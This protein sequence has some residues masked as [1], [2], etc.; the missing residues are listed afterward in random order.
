MT[1]DFTLDAQGRALLAAEIRATPLPPLDPEI[2]T[3]I[4]RIHRTEITV[5]T[6]HGP[7][8]VYRLDPRGS[9]TAAR[10][11]YINFHGG[12]FVRPHRDHDTAFC[13][14][15]ALALDCVVFDVDYRLAPEH[16]F[17]IPAEEGH[18]VTTWIIRQAK[19]LGLD[20]A[21]IVIGGHSAGANL[22]TVICQMAARAGTPM[23]TGQYL[24]YPF[25]DAITPI[26][27]KTA[28]DSTLP[29]R[30]MEAYNILYADKETNLSDPRLSPVACPPEI[31]AQLPTALLIIAG[32]DPLRHE[33]RR[34]AGQLIAAGVDTQVGQFAT[35]DHGFVTMRH[36]A[37]QA[38]MALTRDWLRHR[39]AATSPAG[40]G[41]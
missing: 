40:E 2:R 20:P 14:E 5:P 12:G 11:A 3:R 4:A 30:R 13:A 26:A 17:P 21:R 24:D 6:R 38:A 15:L 18:D 23:P 35:S 7:A 39:F 16:P 31:L 41:L 27:A 37:Y 1:L 9:G 10:P 36:G 32:R 33:A 29:V 8:R 34:Y 22:A 25:V 19:A 28:P